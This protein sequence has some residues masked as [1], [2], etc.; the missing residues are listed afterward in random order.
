MSSGETIELAL[1]Y[2]PSR[3]GEVV[4]QPNAVKTL[5]EFGK[6][7]RIPHCLLFTG[8]SG[9]GKTTLARIV[10]NKL[11]CS[12]MDFHEVNAAKERGI[13]MVRGIET[14]MG[15]A[16][17]GGKVRVWL[18]DE[19]SQLTADAQGGFLK[20]LEEPPSHVYFM[21]ATTHPQKLKQTI[22]TRSTMIKLS[23]VSNKDM[24]GLIQRVANAEGM[25]LFEEVADK[26]V[27]LAGGSCRK[28]LVLLNQ[29]M[30][31]KDVEEQ[32]AAVMV[33]DATKDAIEIA[34]VLIR[35]GT[36]W[37]DVVKVLNGI[38]GLDENAESIRWLILSYMSSVALKNPKLAARACGI[39]DAFRE[40]WYD[41]KRAGLISACYEILGKD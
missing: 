28:A 5:V 32:M 23:A 39:I 41:C 13:D 9:C 3:F 7:N 24:M 14:R 30:G 22:I 37:T 11:K 2:R 19:S 26:I 10:T 15:A 17:I 25:E 20:V 31:D 27:E 12:R 36:R 4:G 1:K 29:A 40:N 34:R 33:A 35:P 38:E 16:P 8:P 6:S 18:I 21:L